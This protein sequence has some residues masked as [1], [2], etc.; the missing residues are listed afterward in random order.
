MLDLPTL[1]AFEGAI[2]AA[3]PEFKLGYKN[4]SLL[5]KFM[6]FL[7]PMNPDF[8][9]KLVT[10]MYPTIYFPSQQE[11]E[12]N[13]KFSFTLLSHE[14]VHLADT[15]ANPLWFRLSYAF[16]QL[17]AI[18]PFIAFGVLA[19]KNAWILGV[20]FGSYLLGC[21]IGKKSLALY[22]VLAVAGLIGS[23]VLAVLLT[24]WVS[25]ALFLGLS[26][27]APWPAPFRTKWEMR[28]YAMNLAVTQWMFGG[29]PDFYKTGLA[30]Y[31][32]GG[33]YY[34]MDWSGGDTNKQLDAF[35]AS[36][37]SGELQKEFPYS[38]V[39]KFMSD[40]GLLNPS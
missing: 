22:V 34:Y 13:P 10:T 14:M 36:A 17:L 6:G 15:K 9:T 26:M 4:Q 5:M 31:F 35:C 7:S 21:L 32:T 23:G 2:R 19:G 27:V 29:V 37:K 38:I 12:G 28:G 3:F 24:H 25:G 33:S 18:F 39:Y 30:S 40:N 11:Y 20:L 16:P 8:M 1:K